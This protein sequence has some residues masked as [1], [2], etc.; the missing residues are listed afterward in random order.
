MEKMLLDYDENSVITTYDQT[1]D[2]KQVY[3]GVE[4]TKRTARTL[5]VRAARESS[6]RCR[7]SR[8]K[9]HHHHLCETRCLFPNCSLCSHALVY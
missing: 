4:V 6:C 3:E 8:N 2:E 9:L 1:T 7:T 5:N